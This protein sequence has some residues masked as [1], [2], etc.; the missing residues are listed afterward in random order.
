[1]PRDAS[2]SAGSDDV[3]PMPRGRW[4]ASVRRGHE[5]DRRARSS[6]AGPLGWRH[7]GPSRRQH[8]PPKQRGRRPSRA[9][10]GV[11]P[12]ARPQLVRDLRLVGLERA[13]RP[14][15]DPPARPFPCRCARSAGTYA[16]GCRA[17]AGGQRGTSDHPPHAT[18]TEQSR[19]IL[20]GTRTA[21]RSAEVC[22]DSGEHPARSYA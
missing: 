14:G 22:L 12:G 20:A 21:N 19:P 18:S 16:E 1:M 2:R 5:R 15:V 10:R 6:A 8:L 13:G 4:R 17:S 9:S 3:P 11:N 7:G